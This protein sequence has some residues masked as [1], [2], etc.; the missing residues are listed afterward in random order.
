MMFDFLGW[1]EAARLIEN[2]MEKTIQ[3]KQVTYDFERQMQGAT[4]VK[5]SEFATRMIE[6]MG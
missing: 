2:S 3:Q 1:H 6:N 5:T 4:K